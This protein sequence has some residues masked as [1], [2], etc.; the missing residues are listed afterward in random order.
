MRNQHSTTWALFEEVFTKAVEEAVAEKFRANGR[1]PSGSGIPNIPVKGM[2]LLAESLVT[3][4]KR[5]F[6]RITKWLT[7]Q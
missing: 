3:F 6:R 5:I 1:E 7:S 4:D 2:I